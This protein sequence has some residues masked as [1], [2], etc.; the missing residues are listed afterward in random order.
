[1]DLVVVSHLENIAIYL[2]ASYDFFCKQTIVLHNKP[3][4]IAMSRVCGSKSS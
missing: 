1:M 4:T 2:I 3:T